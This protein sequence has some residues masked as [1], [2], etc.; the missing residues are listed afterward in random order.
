MDDNRI[1]KKSLTSM[2]NKKIPGFCTA[3]ADDMEKIGIDNLEMLK[4]M[5]DERKVVKDMLVDVQR[6]RL[7][8]DM[9]KGSKTD[10]MLLNFSF[11]GKTKVYLMHLP[12]PEARIIFLFRSRMFPT[13]SNF[14]KR[15]SQSK[16]CTFCCEVETDEHLF[17][18]CGYVDIH[19]HLWRH[20]TFMKLEC[21]IEYLSAGA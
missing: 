11:D 18:C 2:V 3:L 9:M 5:A 10:A 1:S 19:R 17:M 14:P 16:L 6:R 4:S 21:D 15:W 20:D 8:E 13:K 12:F 7:V